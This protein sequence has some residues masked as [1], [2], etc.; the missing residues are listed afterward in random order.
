MVYIGILRLNLAIAVYTKK[1]MNERLKP[2]EIY[3]ILRDRICLLEY[4]PSTVLRE[5]TLAGEFGVSRTPIRAVLQQLAHDGLIESR[6]GVGNLVTDPDFDQIRDVYQMRMKMAELIGQMN[7]KKFTARH[8]ATIYKLEQ[9]TK[10][11]IEQFSIEEYWQINH[12]LHLLIVSLIGNSALKK[13]WESLYFQAAR[14]W[15]QHA[16]K[17]PDGVAK[18]LQAELNE[19]RRAIEQRDAVAFGYIQRNY[20]AYGFAQ[21]EIDNKPRIRS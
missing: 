21:L 10:Q 18:P 20:I 3:K 16:R 19:M 13:T 5:S 4:P 12:A 9:R 2:T 11:L 7:P 6:D 15:Y 14:I 1:P 8:R 17:Y